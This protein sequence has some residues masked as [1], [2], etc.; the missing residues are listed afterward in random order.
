MT[1]IY[2][3]A[4]RAGVSPT[5]VSKVVNG[6]SDVSHRTRERV[7]SIMLELGYRP[8]AVARSL[9]TRRTMMIGVFFRD[10]LNNSFRHPLLHSV[11]AS[12]QD[13]VGASGYDMMFFSNTQVESA[14]VG[15]EAKALN[16]GVDGLFLVGVPRTDPGLRELA[17][18]KI[19]VVSVDLDLYGSRA[20][21]LSSDNIEGSRL[22]LRHLVDNGHRCIAYMG[23]RFET[24]PGHDRMLGYQLGLQEL[25]L[26]YRADWVISGDFTEESGYLGARKLLDSSEMP[27]AV[28]CAS[29][30][31][32]IGAMRAFEEMGIRPGEDIS[33]IGFDDVEYARYV[34]PRLTTIR[35]NSLEMG[36][37]AATE[38]LELIEETDK[39][40]SIITVATELVVRESVKDITNAQVA[41]KTN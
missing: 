38:L 19:P 17:R 36:Q 1:T 23:D 26:P 9:V 16:R 30:M 29:D 13:V 15:F 10:N 7:Q 8:N 24:K 5:T 11:I 39:P 31:M 32:A 33:L 40:P 2:D 25:S 12:F 34:R 4:K 21:Y 14:P 35:Q 20:S 41:V 37:R 18:S 27:T 6:Y 22:A 28:F 3:I